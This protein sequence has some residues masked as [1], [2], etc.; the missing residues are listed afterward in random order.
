MATII[1]RPTLLTSGDTSGTAMPGAT[2]TGHGSVTACEPGCGG[3]AQP[4]ARYHGFS[5][6]G[7]G[8][9]VKKTLKVD[10]SYS[11][12]FYTFPDPASNHYMLRYSLN[13]QST[14][15]SILENIDFNLGNTPVNFSVDLP[16]NQD[17]SQIH[18]GELMEAFQF[19]SNNGAAVTATIS[20]IRVEVTILDAKPVFIM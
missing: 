10:F 20:D 18:V 16:V 15:N 2:P 19:G 6:A 8:G 17:L 3:L 12:N 7:L 13:N 9:A 14:Y 5:N 1:R 4:S 11:G